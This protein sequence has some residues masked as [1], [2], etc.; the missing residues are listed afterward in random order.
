MLETFVFILIRTP[1]IDCECNL[2]S[3]MLSF[4]KCQGK[5]AQDVTSFEQG[6]RNKNG[7]DAI[8]H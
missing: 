2:K 3:D 1:Q 6:E 8:Q 4:S 7:R 5:R